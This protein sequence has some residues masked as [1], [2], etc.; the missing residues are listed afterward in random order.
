MKTRFIAVLEPGER[1]LLLHQKHVSSHYSGVFFR[2][3]ASVKLLRLFIMNIQRAAPI[4]LGSD[5]K[6]LKE[7][8]LVFRISTLHF[9][10]QNVNAFLSKVKK[11]FFFRRFAH[12][13]SHFQEGQAALIVMIGLIFHTEK[14][15]GPAA[16]IF[17][18]EKHQ[19]VP[20]VSVRY[21]IPVDLLA[22]ETLFL[23]LFSP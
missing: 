13:A 9:Q 6:L 2:I 11:D 4:A 20:T 1:V 21:L 7:L 19:I 17:I 18:R 15:T 22:A 8:F 23:K 14:S 10:H 12:G 5:L 3:K 16:L